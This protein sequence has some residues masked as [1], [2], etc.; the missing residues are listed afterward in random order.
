MSYFTPAE[1]RAREEQLLET[2]EKNRWFEHRSYDVDKSL[3]EAKKLQ[4]A[5]LM[6]NIQRETALNEYTTTAQVRGMTTFQLPLVRRIY[7]N[8]VAQDLV[9]VQVLPQPSGM[10]HYFDT[11]YDTD[12]APIQRGMRNDLQ[13]DQGR[14]INNARFYTAGRA[15]GAVIGTGDG[16]TTNFVIPRVHTPRWESTFTPVHPNANLQ[17]YVDSQPRTIKFEGTPTGAEVL[18][19]YATG[20][21][22]FGTAPAAN[23]QITADYDLRFEGD[24]S[25]IPEMNISMRSEYITTS[26]RKLKARWTV[27]AEQDMQAY[28]GISV[29]AELTAIAAR[30]IATEI[31]REIIFDLLASATENVNWNA[32]WPGSASGYSRAEYDETFI[33]A[34]YEAEGRIYSKRQVKPS[35]LLAG[36]DVAARLQSMNGFYYAGDAQG[37]AIQEGPR[38]QGTFRNAYNVIVDP[39]FPKN[40]ILMGYKGDTS[41]NAGYIYCPYIGLMATDTMMDPND[42]TPRKGWMRRDGKK[43]ISGDFYATITVTS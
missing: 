2:Y 5:K 35:F 10:I 36:P 34:I 6:E 1:I 27:E 8:L 33:K 25:R 20:D 42:F 28:N 22:V 38:R 19:A 41:S 40:K 12:V 26:A 43:L 4:L 32:T 18:V 11:H 15:R 23:A 24:D 3:S 39:L 37:G 9:A 14:T 17:V 13:G 29:Q 30:E 31:D 7:P 21:I 16:S